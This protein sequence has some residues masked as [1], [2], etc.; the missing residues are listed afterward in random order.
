MTLTLVL[1]YFRESYDVSDSSDLDL[2]EAVVTV[3]SAM[4]GHLSRREQMSP[5][6]SR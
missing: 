3:Q 4:R 5:S 2:D 1:I 6:W